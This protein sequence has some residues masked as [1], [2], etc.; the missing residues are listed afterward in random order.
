MLWAAAMVRV[1][2]P[3]VQVGV[4]VHGDAQQQRGVHRLV[5]AD[6]VGRRRDERPEFDHEGATHPVQR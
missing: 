5:L 2:L 4:D 1:Q 3:V 6:V